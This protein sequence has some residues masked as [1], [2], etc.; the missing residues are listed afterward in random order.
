MKDSFL[1]RPLHHQG[2]GSSCR[3]GHYQQ[4]AGRENPVFGLLVRR[5]LPDSRRS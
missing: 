3:L 2:G 5:S 1:R 4:F